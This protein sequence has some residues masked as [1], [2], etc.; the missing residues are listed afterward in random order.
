MG[1]TPRRVVVSAN[2]DPLVLQPS[3][4]LQRGRHVLRRY[5][6]GFNSASCDRRRPI[7][8]VTGVEHSIDGQRLTVALSGMGCGVRAVAGIAGKRRRQTVLAEVE[9]DVLGGQLSS[10]RTRGA[11]L[12]RRVGQSLNVLIPQGG[13]WPEPIEI[14]RGAGIVGL[15]C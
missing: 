8:L 1:R 5:L 14:L 12:E 15:S 9:L 11:P 4:T 10:P 6:Y 13:V 2:Y 3:L 7:G